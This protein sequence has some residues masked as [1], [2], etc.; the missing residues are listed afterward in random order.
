FN[1]EVVQAFLDAGKPLPPYVAQYVETDGSGNFTG[2]SGPGE[3]WVRY[4]GVPLSVDA[5]LD[6]DNEFYFN[7]SITN[8]IEIGGIEKS[9]ASTS[10]YNERIVRTGFAH[11]YPTRPGGRVLELRDNYP[12]LEVILGSAA[13]T[14]FYFAEFQLLGASLGETAQEFFNK[15]VE[16]SVRR[17]DQMAQNH[18]FP[19]YDEDPVYTDPELAAAGRT[20]LRPGEIEALLSQPA[21][22]LSTNGLEK[23]YIQQYINFAPTPGDLWTTVRRSG[24]PKRGSE[25]FAWDPL[26]SGGAELVIPRRFSIDTPTED[27]KNFENAAEAYQAQGF[28]TG[29]IDPLILNTQ[30]LWFDINNP[31]YGQGPKQ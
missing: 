18:R 6:Q 16:F 4:F 3:P 12:P 13:E 19:Y 27:S 1:G 20:E 21:Y 23:V 10:T 29:T 9:Y 11:I 15:G 31:D 7:Q 26:L 14:M 5:T 2:W 22:D 17:M 30:R 25:Y 28:T 24:I 8:R